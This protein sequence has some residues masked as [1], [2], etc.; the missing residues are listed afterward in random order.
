MTTQ[1]LTDSQLL[2][3]YRKRDEGKAYIKQLE[4]L[5]KAQVCGMFACT[6]F[7]M[8]AA[9][10]I[11]WSQITALEILETIRKTP[12]LNNWVEQHVREKGIP[13]GDILEGIE[14]FRKMNV[15]ANTWAQRMLSKYA[16]DDTDDELSA[17][18]YVLNEWLNEA[19]LEIPELMRL[20]M[21][22]PLFFGQIYLEFERVVAEAFGS[23]KAF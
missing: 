2:R 20:R 10:A 11:E 17:H 3:A 7:K 5:T 19:I 12:W 22:S 15:E 16:S 23:D 21:D 8:I 18:P 9:P 4:S 6:A 1:K 14:Y 13:L